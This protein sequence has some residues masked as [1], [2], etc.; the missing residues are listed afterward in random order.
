MCFFTS[1][2]TF[3]TISSFIL[4]ISSFIALP[5]QADQQTCVVTNDG[6]TICGI[7]TKQQPKKSNSASGQRKDTDQFT[8]L[9]K[10]CKRSST[11]IKCIYSITNKEKEKIISLFGPNLSII[12]NQG[13]HHFASNI[14][15][16][17]RNG[18]PIDLRVSPGVNYAVE[19]TFK[20]I[21]EQITQASIFSPAWGVQFRNITFI[22]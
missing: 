7:L 21:S 13:K 16:G 18:D 6:A 8:Y 14:R 20:N 1:G 2:L 17:G 3:S 4:A 22:N 9:L 10:G 12:D 11:N 5:T 19:V 15:A